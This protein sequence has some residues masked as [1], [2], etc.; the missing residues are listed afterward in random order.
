[1]TNVN[2][3]GEYILKR[4]A[5]HGESPAFT[6]KNNE[7][8]T[9]FTYN[10]FNQ[11]VLR[12]SSSLKKR[13]RNGPF[14][15]GVWGENRIEWCIVAIATWH[16]GGTLVPIM[17][18]LTDFEVQNILNAA[19]VDILYVSSKLKKKGDFGASDLRSLDF[20]S[21][22][23]KIE[24]TIK[25][26]FSVSLS[27]LKSTAVLIF[28]SGTTGQPKGVML[29]HENI[30]CNILDCV[31]I[32]P[33]KKGDRAV[34]ILPLSHMFELTAGFIIALLKGVTISYPDSLK[35]DD[36]LK[37]MRLHKATLLAA[38]PLFFEIIDRNIQG[39]LKKLPSFVRKVFLS[40]G[41]VVMRFPFLGKIIFRTVH[42]A[43]GGHV[44]FF[45]SGGAKIDPEIILRF[46]RLGFRMLQ[47][48][49]LTET[50]PIISFTTYK[51]HR[52]GSVGK[53]VP[54]L[55]LKIDSPNP[56]GDGEIC[57]QG[58]SVFAGYFENPQSTAEV[59]RQGWFH[60][61]DLGRLDQNGFLFITGRIKD[62]IVTPNGKNVYPEEIEEIL[63]QSPKINEV[64]VLGIDSVKGESIYAV[65]SPN[66]VGYYSK[67]ELTDEVNLLC[68]VL[69]DYKRVQIV[70]ILNGEFPKT[71]TKKIKKHVIRELILGGK[72]DSVSNDGANQSVQTFLN[73]ENPDEKWLSEK[74]AAITRK[75]EIWR[76]AQLKTDLGI[77]SL[78]F[79][80]IV[81][82]LETQKSVVVPDNQFEK[83]LKVADLLKL[84]SDGESV[85]SVQKVKADFDY[86]K[87]N[88]L[89]NNVLRLIVHGLFVRPLMKLLFGFRVTG[90]E[91]MGTKKRGLVFTPN[92]TSHL[93]LL[94]VL[95]SRPLF[96]LNKTYAVAA[97]DYFF[98]TP[99]KAFIVRIFFNGVPFERKARV[100]RSFRVCEKI[101]E[102]G[103]NLVIFPEGTRSVSGLMAQ[104]KPGVGRL[105]AGKEYLAVPGLIRGAYEAY[106]KGAKFPRPHRVSIEFGDPLHFNN[107]EVQT[108][109]YATV[110]SH[111]Q[112]AVKKIATNG[113]LA[114][115]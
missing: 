82:L 5:E 30:L 97:D 72:L 106:P 59:I 75:T 80:E 51:N 10:E 54:S 34:S 33:G 76:E 77:D 113:L 6:L 4:T 23:E 88:S 112:E 79:M 64:A 25:S 63:R 111:L 102:E 96:E 70:R 89:M 61:G 103:G 53:V 81:S 39:K 94:S 85:L 47:G 68:Q 101:L 2:N 40:L 62:M 49:G 78:T 104:F 41:P 50:S 69:A 71:P 18:I 28:T 17:H 90:R 109:S 46:Q 93:D 107:L 9:S 55:R 14:K 87:N 35:P 67:K 22:G 42:Q 56:S 45:A 24:T 86:R 8:R 44:K 26:E 38:V 66:P 7:K 43:F 73:L 11:H 1:M 99:F 3:L 110:A 16:A 100:E 84:M 105:L 108:S 95:S 92:H 114:G 65:V 115:L 31:D 48:Y 37:E 29:T 12:L 98:N 60:T 36:V 21:L 13:F 57:V 52:F 83:I 74:L 32:I 20:K 58:K 27:N 15:I 91:K 19:K